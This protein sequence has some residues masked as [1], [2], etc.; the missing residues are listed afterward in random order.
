MISMQSKNL[1]F[2][3]LTAEHAEMLFPILT[4]PA[5]LFFIDPEHQPNFS[6][7]MPFVPQGQSHP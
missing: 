6:Q 2:E 4:T 7:N 1:C 5:V 3:E